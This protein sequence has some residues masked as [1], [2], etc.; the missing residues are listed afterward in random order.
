M[1]GLHTEFC[2]EIRV[3]LQNLGEEKFGSGYTLG[4]H[5]LL[6][7]HH[8]LFGEEIDE[9]KDIEIIW[10]GKAGEQMEGGESA[11]ISRKNIIWYN[12]NI[13]IALIR[14][15]PPS[16]YTDVP[17]AWSNL[18]DDQR[19][20]GT[21]EWESL[22]FLSNLTDEMDNQRRVNP[23]GRLGRFS[24][25]QILVDLYVNQPTIDLSEI[26]TDEYWEGFSG[27]PVFVEDKLI[28]VVRSVNTGEN[29]LTASLISAALD[30][31]GDDMKLTLRDA[32]RS[33]VNGTDSPHKTWPPM[34]IHFPE[35]DGAAL[36]TNLECRWG[37]WRLPLIGILTERVGQTSEESGKT[38]LSVLRHLEEVLANAQGGLNF[39][40]PRRSW[41][42]LNVSNALQPP[43]NLEALTATLSED[44]DDISMDNV[45]P[46][47]ILVFEAP[48]E[49]FLR[50]RKSKSDTNLQ[51]QVKEWLT[52]LINGIFANR[53]LAVIC[54]LPSVKDDFLDSLERDFPGIPV[55]RLSKSFPAGS[56][57]DTILQAWENSEPD[58]MNIPEEKVLTLFKQLLTRDRPPAS[59]QVPSLDS[60]FSALS[61]LDNDAKRKE[62][63]NLLE[64]SEKIN[65][66]LSEE[67]VAQAAASKDTIIADIALRFAKRHDFL[68][69][70]WL[71]TRLELHEDD[72]A[73]FP[74]LEPWLG[75]PGESHFE[76]GLSAESDF[77]GPFV[78][79]LAMGVVRLSMKSE[80]ARELLRTLENYT[81]PHLSKIVKVVL[82][83][84]NSDESN[85]HFQLF[86]NIKDTLCGCRCNLL[87]RFPPSSFSSLNVLE[88]DLSFWLILSHRP[89][90]SWLRII[91]KSDLSVRAAFGL[92]TDREIAPIIGNKNLVQPILDCRRANRFSPTST[93]IG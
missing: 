61:A 12:E 57:D 40:L 13:D 39:R 29:S 81:A 93:Q 86:E 11:R 78:D 10:R 89:D 20:K 8:V 72:S 82:K 24:K 6:T 87:E 49:T 75:R 91:L 14:F 65:S 41:H 16:S 58:D 21:P 15:L 17:D 60:L 22:G 56:G 2:V 19:P 48:R 33:T 32:L 69:D 54:I 66:E 77:G 83:E 90:E 67:L 62:L 9:A 71:E 4:P 31:A 85:Y 36:D 28:A 46:G 25:E 30:S 1:A 47:L 43:N 80:I 37:L 26:G 59:L 84:K 27:S 35:V 7:A 23:D 5:W 53:Q 55:E 68:M 92:L 73:S 50:R 18:I 51:E 70:A 64:R 44:P 74:F 42:L 45:I 52:I 38:L 63:W 79:E 34:R 76:L 3:P 88:D